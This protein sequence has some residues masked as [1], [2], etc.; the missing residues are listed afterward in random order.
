MTREYKVLTLNQTERKV[1]PLT[2][3]LNA[4]AADGWKLARV[5]QDPRGA[6]FGTDL[7]LVR[8]PDTL[9]DTLARIEKLLERAVA[10]QRLAS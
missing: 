9:A 4:H 10:L 3:M 6:F 2:E 5:V 8:E 7:I 1:G